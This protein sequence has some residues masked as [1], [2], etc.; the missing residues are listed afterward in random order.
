MGKPLA[1]GISKPVSSDSGLR[2]KSARSIRAS[3]AGV[4]R[5]HVSAEYKRFV[6]ASASTKICLMLISRSGDFF[7]TIKNILVYDPQRPGMPTTS[8]GELR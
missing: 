5:G 6:F 8:I 1:M 7:K 2:L 4:K 3:C